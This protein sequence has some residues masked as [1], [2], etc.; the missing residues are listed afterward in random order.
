MR[1]A[2][3]HLYQVDLPLNGTFYRMSEGAYTALDSTIVEVVSDSG[4]SGWGE[5]CPV[6]PTYAPAHAS[7]AR[8]AIGQL[9]P[10]LIGRPVTGPLQIRRALHQ[11][12]NGHNYAKAAIDIAMHDLIGKAHGIR[13]CDLLGG[14]ISDRVGS[15]YSLTVG[16]PDKVAEVAV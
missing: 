10:G 8:A 11:L 12:L 5:T 13:V 7:G 6:G 9:A 15:Y 4:I 3:I 1:I 2:E 16:E 14:A